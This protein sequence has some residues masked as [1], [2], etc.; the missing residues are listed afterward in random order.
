MT[1]PSPHGDGRTPA[2]GPS[3]ARRTLYAFIAI[4][5]IAAVGVWL[6]PK[7]NLY[8]PLIVP[9]VAFLAIAAAVLTLARHEAA[10]DEDADDPDAPDI[11]GRIGDE[12]RP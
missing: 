2:D 7:F 8:L 12:D 5:L 4:T 10:D 1:E 9:A 6:L 3:P 11:A